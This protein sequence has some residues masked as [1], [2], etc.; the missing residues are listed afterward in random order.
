[1]PSLVVLIVKSADLDMWTT[2]Q[3]D[4]CLMSFSTF[5]ALR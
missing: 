3:I 2:E 1:M 4:V 5:I